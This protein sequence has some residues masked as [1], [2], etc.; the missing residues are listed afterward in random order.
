MCCTTERCSSV[1]KG[2]ETSAAWFASGSHAWPLSDVECRSPVRG[3]PIVLSASMALARVAEKPAVRA[4][5]K[6]R[7]TARA[8]VARVRSQS[9]LDVIDT[10]ID[11]GLAVDAEVVLGLADIDLIYLR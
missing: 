9:L 8:D 3:L 1:V 11:K 5:R 10:V 2:K 7:R 6:K 4:Q